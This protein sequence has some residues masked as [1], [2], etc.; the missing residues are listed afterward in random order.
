MISETNEVKIVGHW[1]SRRRSQNHKL[2][3]IAA[4]NQEV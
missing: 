1:R 2:L 4:E 3:S